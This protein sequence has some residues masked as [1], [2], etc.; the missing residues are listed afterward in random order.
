M[1]WSWI[2]KTQWKTNKTNTEESVAFLYINSEQSEKEI[3]K[4]FIC[5]SIKK[6]KIIRN[7]LNQGGERLVH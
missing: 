3:L 4:S 5:Y 1:V 2:Q 7:K 6:D